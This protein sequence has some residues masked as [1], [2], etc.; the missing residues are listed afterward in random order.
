MVCNTCLILLFKSKPWTKKALEYFKNKRAIIGKILDAPIDFEKFIYSLE[1]EERY[2][3]R[4]WERVFNKS[5][6]KRDFQ[7][8]FYNYVMLLSVSHGTNSLELTYEQ[9]N[10]S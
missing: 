8:A 6:Y 5:L 3:L 10:I 1:E 2:P 9:F 7:S 4:F